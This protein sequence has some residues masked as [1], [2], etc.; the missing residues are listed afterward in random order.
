M[1]AGFPSF[2]EKAA[3]GFESEIAEGLRRGDIGFR[4]SPIRANHEMARA[5]RLAGNMIGDG[6]A[7]GD[8]VMLGPLHIFLLEPRHRDICP[9]A[10][11]FEPARSPLRRAQHRVVEA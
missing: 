6:I 11:P 9:E 10:V 8:A 5:E 2:R 3:G 7:L 4:K 1:F